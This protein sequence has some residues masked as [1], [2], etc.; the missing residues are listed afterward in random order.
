M[1]APVSALSLLV[2]LSPSL[3]WSEEPSSQPASAP[4]SSQP[5]PLPSSVPAAPTTAPAPAAPA[6]SARALSRV[7]L[8]GV[9]ELGFLGVAAHRITLGKNGTEFDYVEEGGQDNLSVFGRLSMEL[10]LA[11]KHEVVL[12][13]Q[14]LK[15]QREVLLENN[16]IVDDLLFPAGTAIETT[17][18]FPFWRGSYLY[19]FRPGEKNE[20]A[21][22]LSLQL[23]NAT[24]SFRSLD[25][26]LFRTNRD[27]GP[28]PILKG[29]FK[30][31]IGEGTWI[32][33]EADG[34]YAPISYLNGS[35][36]E[37]VGAILDASVRAGV[38]L[39]QGVDAFVNLRYLGGGAVGSSEPEGP[40]DGFVENWL[41]FVTVSLGVGYD[42]QNRD[43]F[44]WSRR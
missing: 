23:R 30:Q 10:Q 16:L 32:E 17:Y 20:R 8:R 40:S 41:H 31:Y 15:L 7:G 24:I 35:D 34:F 3:A 5:A 18:G 21:L 29:K 39:P 2:A 36:N 42:F 4:A 37:V 38:D 43:G 44:P 25:G 6:A 22:G 14:P 13:Y 27:L 26:E 11:P 28:V 1:R 9:G 19:H 33:G 12:L